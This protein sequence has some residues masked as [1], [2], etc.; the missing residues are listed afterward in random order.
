M[1]DVSTVSGV[2]PF[3]EVAVPVRMMACGLLAALSITEIVAVRVPVAVGRKSTCKVHDDPVAT[4]V[5]THWSL[6]SAKSSGS[7][8]PCRSPL[9]KRAA[10]PVF[11]RVTVWAGLIVPT[12]CVG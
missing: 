6:L 10:L 9:M 8:P 7:F 4:N 12:P 1:P 11:V 5:P 2:G 3:G